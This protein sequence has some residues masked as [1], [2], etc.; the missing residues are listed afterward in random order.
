[1][2]I[3]RDQLVFTHRL[4]DETGVDVPHGHS[5]H[6]PRPIEVYRDRP[7]IY[8]CGDFLNDYEGIRGYENYRADL[9]LMYFITLEPASAK[10]V[11]FRIV[12]MQIKRFRLNHTPE[13]DTQWLAGTM[14]IQCERFGGGVQSDDANILSLDWW[15]RCPAP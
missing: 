6:H 7:I 8:G 13:S 11:R 14:N 4:I 3:A 5:S 1:M 9:V 15:R 10:L 12:P 2:L